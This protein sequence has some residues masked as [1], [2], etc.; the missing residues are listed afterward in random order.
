MFYTTTWGC[1]LHKHPDVLDI[2][3]KR[4]TRNSQR[5]QYKRYRVH[6]LLIIYEYI[7]KNI[8]S[9]CPLYFCNERNK[10]CIHLWNLRY[11]NANMANFSQNYSV[12]HFFFLHLCFIT[13]FCNRY[14][15]DEFVRNKRSRTYCRDVGS[16]KR[17]AKGV[18]GH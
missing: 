12:F 18:P 13:Q 11:C 16:S 10:P 9:L 4:Y 6:R 2:E 14:G 17:R 5:M 15:K 3:I 7:F 8:V 1:Y